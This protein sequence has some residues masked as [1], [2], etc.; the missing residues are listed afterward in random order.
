MGN[1]CTLD[2]Q[3]ML[4][5]SQHIGVVQVLF[6]QLSRP[7]CHLG[8]VLGL[9]LPWHSEVCFRAIQKPWRQAPGIFHMEVELLMCFGAPLLLLQAKIILHRE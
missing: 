9:L 3:A 8:I 1:Y 6:K 7:K 5:Q 2:D 4:A